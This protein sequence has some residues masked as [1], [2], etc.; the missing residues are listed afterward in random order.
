[1]RFLGAI[2]VATV[3]GARPIPSYFSPRTSNVASA[4]TGECTP[5]V[6][7]TKE[8]FAVVDTWGRTSFGAYFGYWTAAGAA[9]SIDLTNCPTKLQTLA[10]STPATLSMASNTAFSCRCIKTRV[11]STLASACQTRART[12]ISLP[13][14]C[15]ALFNSTRLSPSLSGACPATTR[16]TA[17]RRPSHGTPVRATC[18]ARGPAAPLHLVF[19]TPA[20]TYAT[21]T[22]MVVA[23]LVCVAATARLLLAPSRAAAA[24][25]AAAGD[26]EAGPSV[27]GHAAVPL[28]AALLDAF[29]LS[30]GCRRMVAMKGERSGPLAALN[31]VRV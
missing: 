24:A 11:V 8:Y 10:R 1:M 22:L 21:I 6:F 19:L 28:W 26:T 15:S 5:P 14:P 18:G 23:A 7:G 4:A 27:K 16:S 17:G 29:D 2:A 25:A 20:G 13:T 31:G 12:L 9:P 3:V 30:S